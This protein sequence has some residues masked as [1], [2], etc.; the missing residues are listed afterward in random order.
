MTFGDLSFLLLLGGIVLYCLVLG[1]PRRPPPPVTTVIPWPPEPLP[2]QEAAP[3][4]QPA[5]AAPPPA[6]PMAALFAPR[7][8]ANGPWHAM[9]GDRLELLD[10][11]FAIELHPL[12]RNAY[13]LFSP[14]GYRLVAWHDLEE[15]KRHGE[16]QAAQRASFSVAP[17]DVRQLGRWGEQA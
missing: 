2:V 9:P 6:D 16:L 14:E 8:P 5:P 13:W 10:T 11:G 1:W 4:T 17:L 15:V 7:Q 12:Y 3:E